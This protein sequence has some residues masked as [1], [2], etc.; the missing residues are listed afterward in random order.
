VPDGQG[1]ILVRG[2]DL[3]FVTGYERHPV[4]L[5]SLIDMQADFMAGRVVYRVKFTINLQQVS[6]DSLGV[7]FSLSHVTSSIR[8]C[9]HPSAERHDHHKKT[10]E[11]LHD[12]TSLSIFWYC[13]IMLIHLCRTDMSK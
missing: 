11:L 13:T 1:V 5:R 9:H 6:I 8:Q 2:L 7:S 12:G 3:D 10:G 4:L